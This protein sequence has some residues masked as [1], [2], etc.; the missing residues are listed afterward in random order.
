M[1]M[2]NVGMLHQPQLQCKMADVR[3]LCLFQ[4]T[5]HV[6]RCLAWGP[7][8]TAKVRGA[9]VSRDARFTRI[10]ATANCEHASGTSLVRS[11]VARNAVMG[12]AQSLRKNIRYNT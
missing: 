12:N 10:R 9:A 1:M 5:K 11:F 4:W 7:R 2:M 8:G 6:R 3:T